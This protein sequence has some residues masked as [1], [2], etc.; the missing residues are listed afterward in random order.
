MHRFSTLGRLGIL[1]ACLGASGCVHPPQLGWGK[2][3]PPVESYQIDYALADASRALSG[4]NSSEWEDLV[5]AAWKDDEPQD[6]PESSDRAV[7]L[8]ITYPHPDQ[9]I[10]SALATLTLYDAAAV[11]GAPDTV[12]TDRG[13]RQWFRNWSPRSRTEPPGTSDVQA[14]EEI[15]TLDI[16]RAQFEMLMSDLHRDNYFDR[17]RPHT[18]SE[19]SDVELSIRHKRQAVRQSSV[20]EPRLD[21]FIRRVY[22]DGE[23]LV[24]QRHEPNSILTTSA[25]QSA[26]LPIN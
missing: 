17:I 23:F 9:G 2:R 8:S 20:P 19:E 22:R 12:G 13:L 15:V 4:G 10:D 5:T 16:P 26:P 7:R 25:A 6:S 18:R 3:N 21:D 24:G 1:I 11:D 14:V